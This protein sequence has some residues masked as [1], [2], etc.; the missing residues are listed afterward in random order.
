MRAAFGSQKTNASAILPGFLVAP[1][2][3]LFTYGT[4]TDGISIVS[5]AS[6][7]PSN[8]SPHSTADSEPSHLHQITRKGELER[9]KE[10]T[11]VQHKYS[12]YELTANGRTVL[13]SACEGGQTN[14]VIYLTRTL[15]MDPLR[16]DSTGQTPLDLC[17]SEE[18]RDVLQT[19]IGN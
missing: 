8:Q 14:M 10:L 5:L 16:K 4:E 3:G 15:C 18:T 13:H 17:T 9:F 11:A 6:S 1:F 19:M 2:Q 12:P 7:V